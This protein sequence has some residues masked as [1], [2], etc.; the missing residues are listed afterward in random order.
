MAVN[1]N[2]TLDSKINTFMFFTR[3][4]EL[5]VQWHS[6]ILPHRCVNYDNN[7]AGLA[8]TGLALTGLA[9]TGLA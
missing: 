6:N 4:N 1:Y 7:A 3:P 9:S 5:D 2:V 8:S